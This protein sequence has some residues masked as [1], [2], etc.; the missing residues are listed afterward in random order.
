MNNYFRS[1]YVSFLNSLQEAKKEKERQEELLKEK[2]IRKLQKLR[3]QMG[4]NNIMSKLTEP[5]QLAQ[6]RQKEKKPDFTASQDEEEKNEKLIKEA[7]IKI[8]EKQKLYQLDYSL[9]KVP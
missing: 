8:L 5:T 3:E 1:R 7:N 4:V 6:I 2:E 9:L